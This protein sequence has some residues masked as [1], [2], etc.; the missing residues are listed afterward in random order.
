MKRL[1]VLLVGVIVSVVSLFFAFR[2]FDFGD[3]WDATGRIQWVWFGLMLAPFVITFMAKVWRWRV[4]FHPDEERAPFGLLFGA[5]MIS[6]IPLPFRMGEVARGIIAGSRS[7]IPMPRVFSTIVVEKVLDVLT[8][9][10]LLGISLPFVEVPPD[11]QGPALMLGVVVTLGAMFL[12]TLV[13]KPGIAHGIA[14][15]VASKLPARFGERIEKATGEVLQ[16]FAPMSDPP[17]ALKVVLWSLGTWGFNVL[18]VYLMLLS[19]NIT[20]SPLAAAVLVV[21][22]NLIMVVPA[23]PGSVGTFELAVITVLEALG[24]PRAVAQS[25]ALFYHFIGLAPVAVLGIISMIQLGVGFGTFRSPGAQPATSPASA[26]R[27]E[28]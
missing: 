2:E 15:F 5:L 24:Q 3:V 16:G 18:T 13:L 21:A 10:L 20:V 6:Y 25:F 27:E 19:F 22:A 12:L 7:G 4:L 28:I 9:L 17:V 1:L 14:H 8:L 11:M 26:T 23:A